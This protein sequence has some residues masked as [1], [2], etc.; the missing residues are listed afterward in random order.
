[1]KI[2]FLSSMPCALSVNDAYLG[3]TDRFERYAEI[4]LKDRVFVRFTPEGALPIG[5]FLTEEIRFTPPTGCEVYLLKDGIAVYARD[6][7]PADLSLRPVA[8]ERFGDFLAT[9][10]VQGTVQLSLQSPR[11]FFVATLP[12]A[13]SVCELSFHADLLFLRSPSSLAVYDQTGERKLLENVL[14]FEVDGDVLSATLPLSDRLGR[15]ADCKWTLRGGQ[16]ERTSFTLRQAR[17]CDGGTEPQK[18]RD[19]LLPY[20]FFESV[21]IGANFD[22]MLC[23]ELIAEKEKI[24]GFLGDFISVTPTDDPHTCALIRKKG[25]D[26]FEAAYFTAEIENG[27]ITDI[28]G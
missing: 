20:A 25:K 21:L 23:D 5:F 14:S 9:V 1:M 10:F 12:P 3:V 27:K 18:I 6:F 2:Y 7:P 17:T 11:G 22:G 4:S 8:Q 26:L 13:F 28:R 19:E 16:P 24:V 15:V